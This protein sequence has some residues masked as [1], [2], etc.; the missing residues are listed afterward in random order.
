MDNEQLVMQM[1]SNGRTSKS[2]ILPPEDFQEETMTTNVA[3]PSELGMKLQEAF[4][5]KE[6]ETGEKIILREDNNMLENATFANSSKFVTIDPDA[7]PARR[8]DSYAFND[9]R[10]KEINNRS[11]YI[12]LQ[13]FY[14]NRDVAENF[15]IYGNI[16]KSE[17]NRGVKECIWDEGGA[18]LPVKGSALIVTNGKGFPVIP[19][20]VYRNSNIYNNRHA[21]VPVKVGYYILLAGHNKLIDRPNDKSVIGI[22]HVDS[23]DTSN[24]NTPKYNCTLVGCVAN[25]EWVAEAAKEDGF[26]TIDHPAVKAIQARIY[27]EQANTAC[28]I[29]RYRERRLNIED[30]NDLITDQ[31]F[32][33]NH[34]SFEN[35]YEAY[36]KADEIL[37]EKFKEDSKEAFPSMYVVASKNF[38]EE[39]KVSSIMVYIIG[40]MYNFTENTTK[41]GHLFIYDVKLQSGDVFSYPDARDE[42]VMDYDKVLE[43]FN[44]TNEV[45][46]FFRRIAE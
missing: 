20:F 11:L 26:W 25:G 42:N 32:L 43:S 44:E 35:I 1:N 2:N 37:K 41:N 27:E 6:K 38:D 12:F 3:N 9:R 34:Q 45:V 30:F 29:K 46:T 13:N 18:P 10:N 40:T 33:S 39:G 4:N 14:R 31:E 21:L 16:D 36:A 15:V 7:R 23:I 24:P 5:E 19:N 28:Y 22:Y 17:K 8:L